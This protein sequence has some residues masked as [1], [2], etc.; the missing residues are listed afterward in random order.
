MKE[1]AYWELHVY[2]IAFQS[3]MHIYNISKQWPQE[4]ND[5]LTAPLRQASRQVCTRMAAAWNGRHDTTRFIAGLHESA[6]Y[7]ATVR[8]W[9][10]FAAECG[11]LAENDREQLQV[12]YD[13]I[14]R[15]LT[16]MILDV[17]MK[18]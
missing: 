9:L 7:A 1:V 13:D 5:S 18:A 17:E 8:V 10:N 3:A 12:N 11:Y 6:S 4:E 16:K 2:A 15:M 14:D